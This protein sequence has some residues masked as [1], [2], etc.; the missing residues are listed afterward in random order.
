MQLDRRPGVI[1]NPRFAVLTAAGRLYSRTDLD[2]ALGAGATYDNSGVLLVLAVAQNY[3]DRS[4]APTFWQEYDVRQLWHDLTIQAGSDGVAGPNS[5]GGDYIAGGGGDDQIFGQLGND[6]IQGDGDIDARPDGVKVGVERVLDTGVP[7]L[8]PLGLLVIHE[9]FEAVTDGD[10][11]I[12]AGGG[13]DMVFGGLGQDDVIGGSSSLFTLDLAAER[14]DG[15][16]YLFGGAGTKT[17]RATTEPTSVVH[18]RDADAIAGDNANIKRIVT[19]AGAF[20]SFNYDNAYGE[21]LVVRGVE[22]LDYVPGG[23]DFR[24]DCFGVPGAPVAP[25]GSLPC[26][27]DDASHGGADEVHGEDGDD[28]VYG[29]RGERPAVRRRRR[30]RHD[31]RLGPRLDLRRQRPG[32]PARR[33]R[34][35]L[36]QP[37]W[38]RRAAV[39]RRRDDA[40]EHR[41]AG[42]RADR[43]DQRRPASS[44]RR[45]TS[46]RSTCARTAPAPTTRCSDPK[47]ANDVIFGG[48]GSRLPARRLG[49]RRDLRRRGAA[50]SRSRSSTPRP[51][52]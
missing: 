11:Y 20:V 47:F 33:R 26:Q 22:L 23:A 46:R 3:L 15:D 43:D 28:W 24:P 29:G 51:A 14:P 5:F 17:D 34:A 30:R 49:R 21:Q 52:R 10:D 7:Y 37:Q 1:T 4:V 40:V 41:H 19:A 9:S 16:D 32:R 44:T 50:E 35:D 38:H 2:A 45:S 12:E 42:Q 8:D 25:A 36:H 18:G 13:A 27:A 39:R 31:R 48:L 6:V